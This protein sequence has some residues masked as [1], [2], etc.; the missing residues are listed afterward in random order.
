[1]L[2]EVER[3]SKGPTVLVLDRIATGLDTSIARLLARSAPRASSCCAAA[4][5][6]PPSIPRAGSAA[7]LAGP[8]RGGVRAHADLHSGRRGRGDSPRTRRARGSILAMERGHL[9]L[10]L[11]GVEHVLRAGDSRLLR[12]R[13]PP[14]LRPTRGDEPCVYYLAMELGRTG[15]RRDRRRG[16]R[17]AETIMTPPP[18]TAE[19]FRRLASRARSTWR[20]TISRRCGR[21]PS[22]AH[23]P[24]GAVPRSS[25]TLG[26]ARCPTPRPSWSVFRTAVLPHAMGNGHP[27]FF[28]WVNSPPGARRHRRDFL[29]AV[30]N[31]SCAGGDHAAITSS[32]PPSA[33][34][35]DLIGFPT[36]GSMGLLA[37]VLGGHAD[38]R[39]RRRAIALRPRTAGTCGVRA[40]QARGAAGPLRFVRGDSCIQKAAELL[41]LGASRS[42]RSPSTTTADGPPRASRRRR[43]RPRRGSTA[44]LCRGER[45]H[46]GHRRID[47]LDALADLCAAERLLAPTS[48]APTARSAR[49][50]RAL[51]AR[52]AGLAPRDS[53]ALDPHSGCRCRWSAGAVFVRDGR[54]LARRSAWCRL[55]AHG[56]RSRFGLPWYSEYGI[57]QT[58]GFAR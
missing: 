36:E 3:G 43:R 45:G 51:R 33:C 6:T 23:D 42:T 27:R 18:S 49:R 21:G 2:P 7:S 14:R 32:G 40:S 53:I 41:G 9:R 56:P 46:G 26:D 58:R 8:A 19:Q 20:P 15:R 25:R 13:L 1:M 16:G 47:P 29:A 10:T 37:T 11:D 34:S 57:Q 12:R 52:Y 28:G 22:F 55:P 54:L 30:L 39:S 38:P 48:T 50:C 24:R 4:S 31:P 44:V 17:V 5:T 35:L